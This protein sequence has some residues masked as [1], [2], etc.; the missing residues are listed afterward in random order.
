M[1]TTLRKAQEL[2][3]LMD[4]SSNDPKE[5]KERMLY[6]TGKVFRAVDAKQIK[7]NDEEAGLALM[8]LLASIAVDGIGER[9]AIR[10]E[11]G[12]RTLQ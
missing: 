4:L 7:I 6:L 5:F 12:N 3:A 2:A 11:K 9:F 8:T 10:H 1:K